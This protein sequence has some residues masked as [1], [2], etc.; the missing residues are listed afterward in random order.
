M[1]IA[2]IIYD[3]TLSEELVLLREGWDTF[4]SAHPFEQVFHPKSEILNKTIGASAL[5]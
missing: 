2:A 1:I 5:N 3:T 4:T